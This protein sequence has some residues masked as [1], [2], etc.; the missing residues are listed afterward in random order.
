MSLARVVSHSLILV[1]IFSVLA[2]V[3]SGFVT[4]VPFIKALTA[5]G[6]EPTLPEN[7]PGSNLLSWLLFNAMGYLLFGALGLLT[8]RGRCAALSWGAKLW[9][10]GAIATLTGLV[11]AVLVFSALLPL[12]LLVLLP[13]L[14]LLAASYLLA[15]MLLTGLC[16]VVSR[17]K[18]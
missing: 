16:L 18:K 17:V 4:A 9:V 1:V 2:G 14:A 15:A 7:F 12:P 13:P 8:I 11:T 3:G 5:G 10:G 6:D